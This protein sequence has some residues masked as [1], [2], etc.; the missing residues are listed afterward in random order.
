MIFVI[1]EYYTCITLILANARGLEYKCQGISIGGDVLPESLG[2][3][4]TGLQKAKMN[5]DVS[6]R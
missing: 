3:E 5:I 1:Q 2:L 4:T 6:S